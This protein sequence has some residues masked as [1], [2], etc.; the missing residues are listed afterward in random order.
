MND[1]PLLLCLFVSEVFLLLRLFDFDRS[2]FLDG[3]EMMKLL[4]DYN[5]HHAPEAQ[6][7]EK[8]RVSGCGFSRTI[9][10]FC[11]CFAVTC[12]IVWPVSLIHVSV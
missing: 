5:T 3:L 4:S 9:R 7:S 1:S 10:F 6:A 8:V 12:A 2:G 11:P